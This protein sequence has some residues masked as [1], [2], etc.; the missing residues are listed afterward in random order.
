M[1]TYS[2][3]AYKKACLFRSL[4]WKYFLCGNK[5]VIVLFT[6]CPISMTAL[7]KVLCNIL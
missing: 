4:I 5:A 6:D 7:L 1:L 3:I 2:H